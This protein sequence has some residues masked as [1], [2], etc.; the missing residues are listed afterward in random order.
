MGPR[1]EPVA[2]AP[3]GTRDPGGVDLYVGGVELSNGYGELTDA[4][5]QRRRFVLEQ[6]RRRAEKRTVYPL[7]ETFLSALAEG[8][9]P[10]SGNALGFDRLV[11]LAL[12]LPQ[13]QDAVAFPWQ[14]KPPR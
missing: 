12:G 7:D 11:A 14:G 10:S 8:M 9:P 1:A 3:A 13:I 2:G 4:G 6:K 5:E